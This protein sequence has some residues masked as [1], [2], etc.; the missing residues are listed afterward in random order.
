[1]SRALPRRP[2]RRATPQGPSLGLLLAGLLALAGGPAHA[3][4]LPGLSGITDAQGRYPDPIQ[5]VARG[6]GQVVLLDARGLTLV[7]RAAN[8]P[9]IRQVFL[10]ANP[11]PA[12]RPQAP[13]PGRFHVL[14]GRE[15]TAWRA[16]LTRYSELHYAD[17]Y[18]GVDLVLHATDDGRL[19]RDLLVAPGA[20]PREIT[21]RYE[22]SVEVRVADD[23]TLRVDTGRGVLTEAAPVAWQVRD[24]AREPVSVDWRVDDE[25]RVTYA[26]GAYDPNLP[27]TID[28]GL[29]FAAYVGGDGYD[30]VNAVTTDSQGNVYL[31]GATTSVDLPMAGVSSQGTLNTNTLGTKVYRSRDAFVMKLDPQGALLWA[32]F[33]GGKSDKFP[34]AI[35]L[36]DPPNAAGCSN[37]GPPPWG[38]GGLDT[39]YG[40]AVRADGTV[41]VVGET[42]AMDFPTFPVGSTIQSQLSGRAFDPARADLHYASDAFF[43]A[44]DANGSPELSTYLGGTRLDVARAV[45][46]DARGDA[47]VV[48]QTGSPTFPTTVDR[49]S[50][51]VG[52]T[53]AGIRDDDYD[54]F[55]CA[56]RLTTTSGQSHLV[57]STFLG[58]FGFDEATAVAA[59]SSLKGQLVVAGTTGATTLSGGTPKAAQALYG[60]GPTDGF[61]AILQRDGAGSVA[62]AEQTFVGGD[63]GD[64]ISGLAL[65]EHADGSLRRVVVAGSTDSPALWSGPSA[66]G[67]QAFE[68]CGS[69]GACDATSVARF[70][71]GFV[72]AFDAGGPLGPQACAFRRYL[73]GEARDDARGLDVD[74]VTGEVY[75]S[76]T[77]WSADFPTIAALQPSKA[78]GRSAGCLPNN[79]WDCAEN[80][81]AFF[82][83]LSA[84]G[85]QLLLSSFLGGKGEGYDTDD[86][87][88]DVAFTRAG[89]LGDRHVFVVGQTYSEDFPT[90]A[91]KLGKPGATKNVA[92]GFLVR[93]PVDVADLHIPEATL[94]P[95]AV[96]TGENVTLTVEVKND[97]PESTDGLRLAVQASATVTWTNL[98][99]GCAAGASDTLTCK[100]PKSLARGQSATYTLH[101]VAP[102]TKQRLIL[103]LTASGTR[104]DPNDA[105]NRVRVT[106]A[107][108][109]YDVAVAGTSTPNPVGYGEP[110]TYTLSALNKG[111]DQAHDVALSLR[112][113]KTLATYVSDGSDLN[114]H[115]AASGDEVVCGAVAALAKG[116][117]AGPFTVI[118]RAPD[119]TADLRTTVGFTASGP[120][121]DDQDS[122]NDTAV[123]VTE[124]RPADVQLVSAVPTPEPAPTDG[125][126]TFTATLKNLGPG[127]AK[128]PTLYVQPD[129]AD[130][131]FTP[132]A[133]EPRCAALPGGGAHQAVCHLPKQADGSPGELAEGASLTFTL[134]YHTP[135]ASK[136][137]TTKLNA[138]TAEDTHTANDVAVV[139]SHIGQADVAVQK[140]E[141]IAPQAPPYGAGHAQSLHATLANTTADVDAKDVVIEYTSA[142]NAT[143]ATPPTEQILAVSGQTDA[144]GNA[145]CAL[146]PPVRCTFAT[147]AKGQTA[148]MTVSATP[149]RRGV[150]THT[151]AR[152]ASA[153]PDPNAAND[154]ATLDTTIRGFDLALS[155]SSA[156]P[157]PLQRGKDATWVHHIANPGPGLAAGATTTITFDPT[158]FAWTGFSGVGGVTTSPPPAGCAP[159]SPGVVRCEL[160]ALDAGDS[161]DL[162]WQ[163]KPLKGF[164]KASPSDKTGDITLTM[165]ATHPDDEQSANDRVTIRDT[166]DG[167]DLVVTATGPSAPVSIGD[168][169]S[170]D[171]LVSNASD[172]DAKSPR[173]HVLFDSTLLSFTSSGNPS[174]PCTEVSTGNLRCE[175]TPL[176]ANS[177][178][179]FTA[180]VFTALAPGKTD[181]IAKITDG[182]DGTEDT[183]DSDN[184]ATVSAT[185]YGA[186]LAL[187]NAQQDVPN[188]V[189][190][191]APVRYTFDV[192]NT[193]TKADSKGLSV[194]FTLD[195]AAAGKARV[196]SATI[197]PNDTPCAIDATKRSVVCLWAAGLPKAASA[198]SPT[199]LSV[200]IG[201]EGLDRGTYGAA[202]I[203]VPLG[204]TDPDPNPAN[205][206]LPAGALKTTREGYDLAVTATYDGEP[207]QKKR[208]EQVVYT[209]QVENKHATTAE[210]VLLTAQWGGGH[211]T[212][213]TATPLPTGCT[214]HDAVWQADCALG[215][216]PKG[217]KRTL[218][219]TLNAVESGDETLTFA[220]T[221]TDNPQHVDDPKTDDEVQ[222][223]LHVVGADLAVTNLVATSGV[224][225]SGEALDME[226]TV[227]NHSSPSAVPATSK[228]VTLTH[229]GWG[230]APGE[231]PYL[232]YLGS[233]VGQPTGGPSC[234][235][236]GGTLKCPVGILLTDESE[237]IYLHY[238]A[239]RP[240]T[241]THTFT[242][243]EPPGT[244][245]ENPGDN[246]ASY[247]RTISGPDLVLTKVSV[248]SPTGVGDT[249]VGL[250]YKVTNASSDTTAKSVKVRFTLSSLSAGPAGG[251]VPVAGGQGAGCSIL[252]G[253]P[254]GVIE[255][256]LG[257]LAPGASV[258]MVSSAWEAKQVGLY[259]V[260]VRAESASTDAVASDNLITE[261]VD[262]QGPD[263]A[264]TVTTYTGA[265]HRGQPF[266]LR[267]SVSNLGL[268]VS[269][270]TWL[271]LPLA[272]SITFKSATFT[273]PG[274]ASCAPALLPDGQNG[275]RCSLGELTK[276]DGARQ[277]DITLVAKKKGTY[278]F[279]F[280]A[281][282]APHTD[283]DPNNQQSKQWLDFDG[284]DLRVSAVTG[285]GSTTVNHGEQV[286]FDVVLYDDGP[287]DPWN[288]QLTHLFD[289]THLA[290][291]SSSGD[292]PCSSNP[293]TGLTLCSLDTLK[294][295]TP[296]AIKLVY[297]ALDP[298]A[299][300]TSFSASEPG[301]SDENPAN[302]TTSKTTTIRGADLGV[303]L[304]AAPDPVSLGQ[305]ITYTGTVTNHGPAQ[306]EGVI[307]SLRL[308]LEVQFDNA[309]PGCKLGLRT[310][311]CA[312]RDM[313]AGDS[314]TW[315]VTAKAMKVTPSA[316]ARAS[317]AAPGSEEAGPQPD[318]ATVG[319]AIQDADTDSDGVFSQVEDGVPGVGGVQGDGNGDGTPDKDQANV[320][321]FPTS[322]GDYITIATSQGTLKNVALTTPPSP[323]PAGVAFPVGAL[324]Y[325]V[326]GLAAGA[327]T[328][329]TIYMPTGI[330]AWTFWKYG[331]EPGNA[332]PHWYDFTFDGTTGAQKVAANKLE[333]TLVDGA[334]G[335]DDL[336]ANGTIVD[337]GA[338]ALRRLT[339]TSAGDAGDA[340]PGDGACDTGDGSCTLRAALEESNA[341]AP[342]HFIAFAIPAATLPV[343]VS[344]PSGLPAVTAPVVVDGST[345]TGWVDG[346]GVSVS[347]PAWSVTAGDSALRWLDLPGGVTLSGAG[348][349]LLTDSATG[350]D[351]TGVGGCLVRRSTLSWA[352]VTGPAAGNRLE[353]NEL[354]ATLTLTDVSDTLVRG[355]TIHG[356]WSNHGIDITGGGAT[357]NRVVGNI[358]GLQADG[359]CS[360][361]AFDPYSNTQ[362]GGRCQDGSQYWGVHL[363]GGAWGNHIGGG[364]FREGNV[365]DANE[366]GGVLIDGGA[367][368]NVVAGNLFGTDLEGVSPRH[369]VSGVYQLSSGG[370]CVQVSDASANLIGG[371][372]PEDRNVCAG[373]GMAVLG[374]SSDGNTVQGNWIM[375]DA[376]GDVPWVRLTLDD[377]LLVQDAANT[378]VSDNVVPTVEIKGTA[379]GTQVQDN[380]IGTDP[381]GTRAFYADQ[382]DP[383]TTRI[384]SRGVLVHGS[385]TSTTV[386][387]NLISGSYLHGV[388]IWEYATFVT[389]ANNRIGVDASGV[390]AL[391]NWKS[392]IQ[393]DARYGGT[394]SDVLLDGNVVA[395]NG[396]PDAWTSDVDYPFP[397]IWLREGATRVTVQDNTVGLGADKATPL[398]HRNHG[399]WANGAPQLTITGNLVGANQGDGILIDNG[400]MYPYPSDGAVVQGNVV[401][402]DALGLLD[403]GNGANGIHVH[404]S[405]AVVVGGVAAG[406]GNTAA[407]NALAGIWVE[408]GGQGNAV[409]GNSL[410]DNG[411]LGVDL[412]T[413]GVDGNGAYDGATNN[414]PEQP[415]LASATESAGVIT[416]SGTHAPAATATFTLD[417]YL[418]QA[419][420]PTGHG[421][422]RVWLGETTLSNSSTF[423]VGLPRGGGVGSFVTATAT[424]GAGNTS[425][426][427]RYAWI[428]AAPAWTDVGV[429]LG[430]AY[431]SDPTAVGS[432][433][434]WYADVTV[435]GPDDAANVT[436]VFDYPAGVTY[437]GEDPNVFTCTSAHP[438]TTCT[439]AT[440]PVGT[441]QLLFYGVPTAAGVLT[442]TATVSTSTTDPASGNDQDTETTTVSPADLS[443]AA[444]PPAAAAVGAPMTLAA[445]VSNSYFDGGATV[446]PVVTLPLPAGV[447][448]ASATADAGSCAEAGGLVTCSL[449]PLT[450]GAS[451]GLTVTVVPT[452]PGDVTFSFAVTSEGPDA[453]PANNQADVAVT[454]QAQAYDLSV[455]QAV[456]T[457]APA[458]GVPYRDEITVTNAGPSAA[459]DVVLTDTL[460]LQ[461]YP[462]EMAPSQGV[463]YRD[464]D[465]SGAYTGK[466]LCYLGNLAAGASATILLDVLTAQA[467]SI[468]SEACAEAA[469]EDV[470]PSYD[471]QTIFTDVGAVDLAP[472]LTAS[473]NPGTQGQP[474]TLTATVDNA[475]PS[476]AP[477]ATVVVGM[478]GQVSYV[479]ADAPCTL[480]TSGQTGQTT[481][482]CALGD[483]PA[484]GQA[485]VTLTLDATGSGTALP[486]TA[487]VSSGGYDTAGYN[488]TAYLNLDISGP[489][490]GSCPPERQ[491]VL[492]ADT[493]ETDGSGWTTG[494]YD[495]CSAPDCTI[496]VWS[497]VSDAAYSGTKS[498]HV[499]GVNGASQVGHWMVNPVSLAGLEE[500]YAVFWHR[501]D[502]E[503]G[504]DGGVVWVGTPS[505]GQ[506]YTPTYTV[507][508]PTVTLWNSGDTAYSGKSPAWPNFEET[509]IDLAGFL[510]M[511]VRLGFEE[512]S[513]VVNGGPGWWVDGL[514]IRGCKKPD[515]TLKTC[516]AGYALTELLAD[517]TEAAGAGWVDDPADG[518]SGAD[519]WQLVTDS[520]HTGS[521]SWFVP[522]FGESSSRALVQ[523]VDIDL[524]GDLGDA[525]VEFFHR[526]DFQEGADGGRLMVSTDAGQTWTTVPIDAYQAGAPTNSAAV[527][528][529]DWCFTGQNPSGTT[530]DQVLVDLSAYKG[531]KIRLRFEAAADG[532]GWGAGWWVDDVTARACVQAPPAADLALTAMGTAAAKAEVEP[533]S[534]AFTVTNGGPDDATGVVVNVNVPAGL[535]LTSPQCQAEMDGLTCA[536]GDL[537]VGAT[538]T[539][540]LEGYGASVGEHAVAGVVSGAEADPVAANDT[541]AVTTTVS[542]ALLVGAHVEVVSGPATLTA[543]EA[544]TI[545]WA[546]SN[547]GPTD[548]PL[549]FS[550][551]VPPRLTAGAAPAG[552]AQVGGDITC[553]L[554]TVPAGAP[555]VELSLGVT[556]D[557]LGPATLT[558]SV[559]LGAGAPAGAVDPDLGDNTSLHTIAIGAPALA[560]DLAV[561]VAA[562]GP[563]PLVVD[564]AGTFTVTV[565]NAGPYLASDVTVALTTTGGAFEAA[566][567]RT[568]ATCDL[569]GAGGCTLPALPAGEAWEIAVSGATAAPAQLVVQAAVA[570]ATA[571]P[572]GA[573]DAAQASLTAQAA[574]ADL[575]VAWTITPALTQPGLPFDATVSAVNDGPLAATG[576]RLA[577]VVT[578]PGRLTGAPD[579]CALSA[580]GA[581]VSCE[582]G[583]LAV[584]AAAPRTLTLVA[585]GEGALGLEATV[586]S[587]V[588]DDQAANDTALATITAT[589]ATADLAVTGTF[590]APVV[591]DGEA[592]AATVGDVVSVRL[593]VENLSGD[594]APGTRLSV[595]LPE[596]AQGVAV[597]TADGVCVA[598][599]QAVFCSLGTR[600]PGGPA[601]QVDVSFQVVTPGA[602]DLTALVGADA[603]DALDANDAATLGLTV[604]ADCAGD[605][606][607]DDGDPCTEDLCDPATGCAHLPAAD[608]V[609][610][611]DGD[612]CTAGDA[613]LAGLCLGGG[614]EACDD[615]D[616]CTLDTCD[617]A[618][619]CAHEVVLQ[620]CDDGDA[621]TTGDVCLAGACVGG[622]SVDCDDGDDCTVDVCDPVAGCVHQAAPGCC[623]S[624]DQCDD[625]NPCTA[626]TCDV[627]SGD[628]AHAAQ[629]DGAACN[630]DGDPC[631]PEECLAGECVAAGQPSCDD[632]DPCTEDACDPATGCT[633][634]AVPGCCQ[635]DADCPDDGDA[636]TQPASCVEGSCVAGAEVDCDDGDPC[637][638]ESCDPTV[639][640]TSTPST[641]PEC[642]CG[643]A[644][645]R[646]ECQGTTL[647]WLD[648]CGEQT[649][650]ALDCDDGDANTEDRCDADA[651]VCL[652]V[653]LG[654]EACDVTCSGEWA[655][656]CA[657]ASPGDGAGDGGDWGQSLVWLDPCGGAAGVAAPC[658][659]VDPCVVSSCDAQQAACV[660]APS[661]APECAGEGGCDATRT[662]TCDGG[663][664]VW[665][666]GCGEV[667]G[668]ALTGDDGDPTTT[669]TCDA[670]GGRCVHVV[671]AQEMPNRLCP[672]AA[673]Q[674]PDAG[675]TDAGPT[676]TG[677]GDTGGGPEVFVDGSWSYADVDGGGGP[678]DDDRATVDHTY[679][680]DGGGCGS[681]DST[682]GGASGRRAAPWDTALLT[683]L[684]A[685]WL[686]RRRQRGA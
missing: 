310:V 92:N 418:V 680:R 415:V 142:T 35:C 544:G 634:A 226:V 377:V 373:R 388:D 82:A 147:L 683:L 662:L 192:L 65:L 591:A 101:F 29:D 54:A 253:G 312:P 201:T 509:R 63:G 406:E 653:P 595:T 375:L 400:P 656:V 531:Q 307:A 133:Y 66:C 633:H 389:V 184:T 393:V 138:S 574:A 185:I 2:H 598:G 461:A 431:G 586:S 513:D 580:S 473:P 577:V 664:L 643:L 306:A 470:D 395:G 500:A 610:C 116:Q 491:V 644:K 93:A 281:R 438:Q 490:A 267:A 269:S 533:V 242:A 28:P 168:P 69:D 661:E 568:G 378:V 219:F 543:G 447:T 530:F 618:L 522:Y 506:I 641:A 357:G 551:L 448:F 314:Y 401:G 5:F 615:G 673:D 288:A 292:G 330:P 199:K 465:A 575:G 68:D 397:G 137:V 604:S 120:S 325:Q 208:G 352:N 582:L 187:A 334:R 451:T 284:A 670:E 174:Y 43:V 449:D 629:P 197:G 477:G 354:S 49:L 286:E 504:A 45:T 25:G 366:L 87:G 117:T 361:Y 149:A 422:G 10:G 584:G 587:Q 396:S 622:A 383:G 247:V 61:V 596:G 552:C 278:G 466:V 165:A 246:A 59:T 348:R 237:T 48:G 660:T 565:T 265:T 599:A 86:T 666:D 274:G 107:V 136:T 655:A 241:F 545:T 19:E 132:Q 658:G 145:T 109:G 256:A 46:F 663:N 166:V 260:L 14:R 72:V 254:N 566:T 327:T 365:I 118:L 1:M 24:G 483:I 108:G 104:R 163:L 259:R 603:L 414:D 243:S 486:F 261:E 323:T 646:T 99:A 216:I 537:A 433:V 150:Q 349:D 81:D 654:E 672:S 423:S 317:A 225:V 27:L 597:T 681:C 539:L 17:L 53:H 536:V 612:P 13:L 592:A 535:T 169:V 290:F 98:P 455:T 105:N 262:V 158:Y 198:T 224:V 376:R 369:P 403:L 23:G 441:Y 445:T 311:E 608:G 182:P 332:T 549:T 668:V 291:V 159:T 560:A 362:G 210:A 499:P 154:K 15:T 111:P 271:D 346:P 218:T 508:P 488:D 42:N 161:R 351:V 514:E 555:A 75:V 36:D 6:A 637:T 527:F 487:D 520:A 336:S 437:G 3:G 558:A 40:V 529:Y 385:S 326:A 194:H 294:V 170:L 360:G 671:E 510:D 386:S 273:P 176:T 56:I 302:N 450:G 235:D 476:A 173:L 626:D 62:L 139:T 677:P 426:L 338:P 38:L 190:V 674:S 8:Q 232:V 30:E 428:D 7:P 266:T 55:A 374:S 619:G 532:W 570:G 250:G 305:T 71:D 571:D 439:A 212:R 339:V 282:T 12:L 244:V 125:T 83:R 22:G 387:G 80:S 484:G 123:V 140:I 215:D 609:A 144:G 639:G 340:N 11:D 627:A 528:G 364:G 398:G 298:G 236:Q 435:A 217:A 97:G 381:S 213:D 557:A 538:A 370:P 616:P 164:R 95:A 546:V 309:S 579:G 21:L 382:S 222:P 33:W 394:V 287:A 679:R 419:P 88:R 180:A 223:T 148:T 562:D 41:A 308:P 380:L 511:E 202:A 459:L 600:T 70:A 684:I 106:L 155:L 193:S 175:L 507:N 203:L 322:A 623:T 512:Q 301:Q 404:E 255:C 645:T 503:Q 205:D 44:F 303:T 114:C 283:R 324:S 211:L 52:G 160:G 100:Q 617:P 563:D 355:N 344:A 554:G 468:Q 167:A 442:A 130:L 452:A 76:G 434:T 85:S 249:G 593:G 172:I 272:P 275:V 424:D 453:K 337:P 456:T 353:D 496:A 204:T 659:S 67:A 220:I 402:T 119:K 251:F 258:P 129:A 421:E 463:C 482:T 135:S 345:Q 501:W 669:D 248:D 675:P 407:H 16:N 58:G 270:Q 636:C 638:V 478:P 474:L 328:K 143:G 460:Q 189:S 392:G 320:A 630:V 682:S 416:V 257:D 103:D 34:T 367:H 238:K 315:T 162:T 321:S 567:D 651:K 561:S 576:A 4:A 611:D 594:P 471:C 207:F 553:D 276:A 462:V 614:P 526:F 331:P 304:T 686:L 131:V 18:P 665:E 412:N 181:L 485:A 96:A 408:A 505:T 177:G 77:T 152:V 171:V 517:T 440:L 363:G 245:D 632:G 124:V 188:P 60:G 502:F 515:L 492:Y 268:G 457:Q 156:P 602:K 494:T 113:D 333:V 649:G 342:A 493:D 410:F 495:S 379:T 479:S 635:Q 464:E 569:A 91:A 293:V 151:F 667:V 523:T 79:P 112:F 84:D 624:D 588:E 200:A 436:L 583:D 621:C 341:A 384:W 214:A 444:T 676:D 480:G 564:Q 179:A 31:A 240:G 228:E 391:P 657:D 550:A 581:G 233:S 409:R 196:V 547:A 318:T 277:V 589:T 368:D 347:A 405:G 524:T 525:Q 469:G 481:A 628:C 127:A 206:A 678:E 64:G 191:T 475:G 78:D 590:V 94:A 620:A 195:A 631:T 90:F 516:P 556:A 519:C 37:F 559:A 316:S 356:V 498:W 518:C 146:G 285:A 605:A 417:F 573:N 51:Y 420:D 432:S 234:V 542:G 601:A 319:T 209:V 296:A 50:P 300:T 454:V 263:L 411:G 122:T 102:S 57:F 642:G 399:I 32:T 540:T 390:K 89:A 427:S 221:H 279:D 467:T 153:T 26:L 443:I 372:A 126:L 74:P 446:S 613:C 343:A 186:D 430:D 39:A 606:P 299:V 625:L 183:H 350:V 73:G 264:L 489:P 239:L 371:P 585:D 128:N 534:Y 607:C 335:D 141:V 648:G 472:T 231:N 329:V 178:A 685:L 548:A 458:V 9:P 121:S 115:L 647:V 252:A 20:D 358:L 652:H 650:T 497:L 578:G 229:T 572:N 157:L 289:Q 134:N 230:A 429:V 413:Q 541:A 521:A 47:W 359:S 297:K 227:R 313:A 640:C 425:E 110:I 295:G 280:T